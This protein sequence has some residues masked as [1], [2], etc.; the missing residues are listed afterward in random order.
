MRDGFSEGRG[1]LH[2]EQA[3]DDLHHLFA[4]LP[5]DRSHGLL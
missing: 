1:L 5:V 2:H 3:V 4:E